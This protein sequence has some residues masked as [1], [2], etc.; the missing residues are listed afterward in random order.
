V[1]IAVDVVD[2]S[3]FYSVGERGGVNDKDLFNMLLGVLSVAPSS[4]TT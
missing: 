1:I 4:E 2:F 3:V